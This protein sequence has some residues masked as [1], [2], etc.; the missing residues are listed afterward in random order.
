[1]QGAYPTEGVDIGVLVLANES[2]LVA[3]TICTNVILVP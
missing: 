1:M 2:V 3:L